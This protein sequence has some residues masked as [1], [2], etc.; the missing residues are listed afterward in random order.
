MGIV[1]PDGQSRDAAGKSGNR[2]AG[3][4]YDGWTDSTDK[5]GDCVC[6]NYI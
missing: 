1:R 6:T 3:D 4:V 5:A 2:D